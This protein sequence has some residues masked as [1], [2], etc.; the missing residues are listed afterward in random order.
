[1]KE[2]AQ[3]LELM[4][5]PAFC[6][7]DGHISA[8]NAAALNRQF[9]IGTAVE[10]LLT[11]GKE[12]Y[13]QFQDGC[14]WL[15]LDC[16]GA[17]YSACVTAV[18]GRHVFTLEPEDSWAELRLLSLAAQ[19]LRDPLGDV[20]SL[21][22]EMERDDD[23]R[24]RIQRGL[25]QMLRV[26]GNM[27]PHPAP[28]LEMQDIGALLRELVEKVASA[29]ESRG[30]E[31]VYKAPA[32]PVYSC[33]DG[34]LLIR[35]VHNLLSNSMKFSESGGRIALELKLLRSSY[36]IILRD[37]A[38]APWPACDPFSRYRREPGLGDGREG[39]GLGLK[40]VQ[41]AAAVHGG[42]VLLDRP[43]GAGHAVVLSLPLRQ[44]APLRSPRLRISYTGERDPMLVELS[45]V[46][47]AEFYKK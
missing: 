34:E 33:A 46:L 43:G 6:A 7:E 15:S 26:L 25:Y 1:M 3:M 40:Q 14:L 29:C 28:R 10:E 16:C 24:A 9:H 42:T 36:Q 44:N 41:L 22:E 30:L 21:V 39:L 18:E 8:A 17:G 37:T 4:D 5:R 35:A 19:T 12:E 13:R 23:R 31:L 2:I 47:P 45:D 38:D 20:L 27:S 11:S 32:V